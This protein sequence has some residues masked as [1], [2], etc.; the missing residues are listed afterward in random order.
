MLY[1]ILDLDAVVL[2]LAGH[3]GAELRPG[4]AHVRSGGG[5][6]LLV[7]PPHLQ[8]ALRLRELVVAA[9]EADGRRD[10]ARE[11]VLAVVRA[12]G[13]GG[14][15]G[16]REGERGL[17]GAAPDAGHHLAEAAPLEGPAATQLVP[18]ALAGE[19]LPL[20]DGRGLRRRAGL[21]GVV[22]QVWKEVIRRSGVISL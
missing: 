21:G 22:D 5:L 13:V 3:V 7:P 14:V 2:L 6:G 8:V 18:V 16:L 9:G 1:P 17:L 11:A 20:Q 12:L 4:V 15:A 10:L 19:R